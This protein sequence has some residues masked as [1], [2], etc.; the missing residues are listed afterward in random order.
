MDYVLKPVNYEEMDT[1]LMKLVKSL[2]RKAVVESV[3]ESI[4]HDLEERDSE[5]ASVIP[6]VKQYI[7]EHLSENIYIEDLAERSAFESAVSDADIQKEEN[8]SIL[9][10]MMKKGSKL[11]KNYCF[12]PIIMLIRSQIW[13]D[14]ETIPISVKYLRE[15]QENTYP[16]SKK[17][18]K[19]KIKG[20][21]E[22]KEVINVSVGEQDCAINTYIELIQSEYKT[23]ARLKEEKNMKKKVASSL[24]IMTMLI[25]V[26]TGCD[27]DQ[28]MRGRNRRQTAGRQRR[29][30]F[31]W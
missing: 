14:M 10:F 17:K 18:T 6:K 4:V 30:P 29:S 23:T 7:I 3:S 24:L 15:K 27:Q 12:T 2:S 22:E 11:R 16:I 25:T 28:R 26:L 31:S 8:I 19:K 20:R 5:N 9:E 13:W 21:K 1:I